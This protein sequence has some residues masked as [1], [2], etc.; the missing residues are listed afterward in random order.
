MERS[1]LGIVMTCHLILL[2]HL[3][4]MPQMLSRMS[5]TI[6]AGML[7]ALLL[8]ACSTEQSAAPNPNDTALTMRSSW[9]YK[10]TTAS[11][12]SWDALREE[13]K[14][15]E[16]TDLPRVRKQVHWYMQHPQYFNRICKRAA[17]YMYY[18]R[19]ELKKRNMPGELALL[20]IIESAY[21][22]FVYSNKGAAGLWQIMPATGTNFGLKQNWWY[23]GR[24]DVYAS[25]QAALNYLDY[26]H[27]FFQGDW[28]LAIAAYD[29]GEGNVLSSM[30]RNARNDENTDFWSLHLSRET[31]TYVPRLLAVANIIKNYEN[32]NFDLPAMANHP[33]F[34]KVNI[35]SQ[36]SLTQAA[37]LADMTLGDFFILN[38]GFNRW[39]TAPNGPHRL[40]LPIDK[41]QAFKQRLARLPQ[42][43]RVNWR[44][45]VV[46][47]GDNLVKISRHYG[48]SV[49]MLKKINKI[50][51]HSALRIGRHLIIPITK[52]LL[53]HSPEFKSLYH[54][55]RAF[56]AKTKYL[57][58]R[59]KYPTIHY[60]VKRGDTL[61]SIANR[62]GLTST[63]L[64]HQ[65][66]LHHRTLYPGQRLKIKPKKIPRRHRH[67]KKRVHYARYK[68]KK[69]DTL[70]KIAQRKHV[71]IA[72]VRKL[73][74]IHHNN[75]LAGQRLKLPV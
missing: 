29:T 6:G 74:H 68:V 52:R 72:Q 60:R 32:Y 55:P 15:P 38:P 42:K 54:I 19:E 20:P 36:I 61:I 58:K 62:Y 7:F 37:K 27:K 48:S 47:R 41:A 2:Q 24:R 43:K 69:G 35:D 10:K 22:P 33:Y 75:I 11:T 66:H 18:I 25:T 34:K 53:P 13:F 71:R 49:R 14:L 16:Y 50:T 46:K 63:Q 44:H 45:H 59:R 40:L 73:N 51:R 26:L 23:D 17:P 8:V 67:H 39:A 12:E 4:N 9:K 65:N 21:D 28:L 31:N 30:K 1:I 64:A 70:G 57:F 5:R 3:F 56:A